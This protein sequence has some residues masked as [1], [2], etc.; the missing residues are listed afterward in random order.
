MK[1]KNDNADHVFSAV[2]VV[3]DPNAQG[4][5]ELLVRRGKSQSEADKKLELAKQELEQK[6]QEL[7]QLQEDVKIARMRKD[8]SRQELVSKYPAARIDGQL[9]TP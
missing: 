8:I 2:E 1:L 3:P 7:A 6:K 5:I 4:G 9:L